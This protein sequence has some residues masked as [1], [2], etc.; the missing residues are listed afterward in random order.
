MD[1]L[2]ALLIG[3]RINRHL[4]RNHK[5]RVEA[6]AEMADDL[7]F[8]RLVL[9]F[10]QEIRRT[11]KSDLVNILFHLRG[12]HAKAV[13][14]Y[15]QRLF[16]RIHCDLDLRLVVVRKGIFPHHIQLLKLGDRIAA[17]GYQLTVKNI[18]IGI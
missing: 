4:I 16:I 18:V 17:V 9:I 5:R 10:F 15:S 13:I 7:I 2:R 11:G 8:I 1:S 14:C 6:Q 12:S 3:Q